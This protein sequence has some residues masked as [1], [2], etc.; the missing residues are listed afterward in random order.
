MGF[1]C[2]GAAGFD[3]H[4]RTKQARIPSGLGLRD[5]GLELRASFGLVVHRVAQIM[6]Q[7]SHQTL[8]V[9]WPLFGRSVEI[10]GPSSI[11]L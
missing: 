3:S 10:R 4:T 11:S 8:K 2:W 9:S 6:E 1:S 7:A 5:L